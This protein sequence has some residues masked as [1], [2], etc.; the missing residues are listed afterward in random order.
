[1]NVFFQVLL[2]PLSVG[3]RNKFEHIDVISFNQYHESG[4]MVKENL[5]NEDL[6]FIVS[7]S[8]RTDLPAFH[9]DWFHQQL[10]Q[11]FVVYEHPYSKEKIKISL[12]GARVAGFVFWSKNYR[13]FFPLLS[14]IITKYRCYFH[15]TITG[16][17]RFL[18]KEVPTLDFS[19]ET[20][21]K[22]AQ[23]LRPGQLIWRYDPIIITHSLTPEIHLARFKKIA[24]KLEKKTDR[25][26]IS[27]VHPYRKILRS[28]QENDL[29]II[30]DPDT[31]L[32]LASKLKKSAA[33]FGI[34]LEGCCSPMLQLAGVMPAA[35]ISQSLFRQ[36]YSD[37]PVCT[38]KKATRK[39][40]NCDFCHDIGHYDSC[41][42]RCCYCYAMKHN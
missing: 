38:R 35:C 5:I 24:A 15:Y 25:C 10:R 12:D 26:I 29:E 34:S 39:H 2:I 9:V 28:L 30:A 31:Q 19:I 27:F 17:G 4:K 23:M 11:G 32:E 40:C 20:F 1:M 22:M 7:A 21:A 13:P 18:E 33:D 36:L 3:P 14:E 6:P 37:F 8:R 42:H 16:Y 41:N